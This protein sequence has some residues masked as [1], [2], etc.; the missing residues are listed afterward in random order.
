MK[1]KITLE[2]DEDDIRCALADFVG[3]ALALVVDPKDFKFEI[4]DSY[5]TRDYPY[6]AGDEF[7]PARIKRVTLTMGDDA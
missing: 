6:N 3:V 2:F 1:K 5:D 4:E 7:Y